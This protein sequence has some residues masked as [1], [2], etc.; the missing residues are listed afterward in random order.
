MITNC[1]SNWL[2]RDVTPTETLDVAG[3]L[4]G[5]RTISGCDGLHL[6]GEWGLGCLSHLASIDVGPFLGSAFSLMLSLE[7][8]AMAESSRSFACAYG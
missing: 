5:E 6:T 8:V 1:G 2:D 7:I 4:T 3:P